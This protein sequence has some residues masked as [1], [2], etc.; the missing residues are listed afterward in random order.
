MENEDNHELDYIIGC[1]KRA[2]NC[3]KAFQILQ[4]IRQNGLFTMKFE[5]IKDHLWVIQVDQ[6]KWI[7]HM[8][9]KIDEAIE[10]I[11]KDE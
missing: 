1:F 9:N 7:E 3:D 2:K 5:E 11:E 6:R 4:E 8:K 10:L